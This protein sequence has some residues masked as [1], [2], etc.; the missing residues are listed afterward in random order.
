MEYGHINDIQIQIHFEPRSLKMVTRKSHTYKSNKHKIVKFCNIRS[1]H[2]R[3]RLL[4]FLLA[5]VNKAREIHQKK[6][7]NK[8]IWYKKRIKHRNYNMGT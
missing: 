8:K 1:C 3:S 2:R 4:V 7:D 5:V 6:K